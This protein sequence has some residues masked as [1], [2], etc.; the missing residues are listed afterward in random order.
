[1]AQG[2]RK[3]WKQRIL[4]VV[5]FYELQATSYTLL[6]FPASQPAGLCNP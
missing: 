1:M 5:S 2:V 6:V 3:I 4:A